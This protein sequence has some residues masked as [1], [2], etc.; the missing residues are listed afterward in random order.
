MKHECTYRDSHE[1]ASK[2]KASS[3][4]ANLNKESSSEDEDD[5][6][7]FARIKKKRAQSDSKS[8]NAQRAAN[9]HRN[10]NH[11]EATSSVIAYQGNTINDENSDVEFNN[12]DIRPLRSKKTNEE[13]K[14]GYKEDKE[15]IST[16]SNVYPRRI[17]PPNP[18]ARPG[19]SRQKKGTSKSSSKAR[20]VENKAIEQPKTQKNTLTK[21][22]IQNIVETWNSDEE[23]IA[24][25]KKTEMRP[26]PISK[27]IR[28]RLHEKRL[29]LH[30]M[31]TVKETSATIKE[32]ESDRER[33]KEK[34]PKLCE[35]QKKEELCRM[36]NEN[37][38]WEHQLMSDDENKSA[39]TN[40]VSYVISLFLSS[41]ISFFII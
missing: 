41:R 15:D 21:E 25:E 18:K 38:S 16:E 27:E 3:L 7:D 8:N 34:R 10:N 11:E 5:K 35:Q 26:L 2:R 9:R 36:K 40:Q 23:E 14:R 29:S 17:V 33:K 37:G 31:E 20:R 22:E 6:Y 19:L 12:E 32:E 24:V 28:S 30:K 39:E 13:D 1:R 4:I